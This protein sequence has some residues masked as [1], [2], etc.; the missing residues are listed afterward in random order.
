MRKVIVSIFVVSIFLILAF[1]CSCSE[2][3]ETASDSINKSSLLW[4]GKKYTELKKAVEYLNN[5]IKLQPE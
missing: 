5:A 3:N 1:L 2:N 4:D